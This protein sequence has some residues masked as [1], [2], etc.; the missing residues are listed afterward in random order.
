[1]VQGAD[2]RL[3]CGTGW[4]EG[5]YDY[6]AE[7]GG[8]VEFD[9]VGDFVLEVPHFFGHGDSHTPVNKG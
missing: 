1:M 5:A 8:A 3:R 2:V 6:G 4:D 9:Y 7:R